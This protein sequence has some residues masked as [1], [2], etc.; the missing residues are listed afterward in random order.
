M[1]FNNHDVF[2][3]IIGHFYFRNFRFDFKMMMG[4]T[5]V[6]RVSGWIIIPIFICRHKKEGDCVLFINLVHSKRSL[7]LF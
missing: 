6:I 5:V 4:R 3:V 1:S 7:I 2:S